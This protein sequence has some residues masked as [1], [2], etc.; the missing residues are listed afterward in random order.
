LEARQAAAVAFARSVRQHGLL[1]SRGEILEQYAIYNANEGRDANT[2]AVL[3]AILDAIEQ[4][5]DAAVT[6]P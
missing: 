4:K 1:L 6:T 3:G 2:H 5:G